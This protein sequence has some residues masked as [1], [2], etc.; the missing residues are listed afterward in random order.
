MFFVF[1]LSK[2]MRCT[3]C[4]PNQKDV[5]PTDTCTRSEP[6]FHYS[7]RRFGHVTLMRRNQTTAANE[8]NPT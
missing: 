2:T 8:T 1:Y 7:S 3:F 6:I 5:V 4:A